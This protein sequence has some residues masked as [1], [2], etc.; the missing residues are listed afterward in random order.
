MKSW[1]V[2]SSL[3]GDT[4]TEIDRRKDNEDFKTGEA[5]AG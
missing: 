4:W 5:T 3:D 1:A 2:E